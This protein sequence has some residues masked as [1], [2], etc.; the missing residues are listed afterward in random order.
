MQS[1]SLLCIFILLKS[2]LHAV[3]IGLNHLF[4]HLTADR[5]CLLAG[6]VTVV[7][8]LQVDADFPRC[9]DYLLKQSY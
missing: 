2:L 1:R 8:V 4:D 9:P 6:E 3:F 7:T 5:T